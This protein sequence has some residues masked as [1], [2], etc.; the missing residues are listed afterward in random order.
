VNAFELPPETLAPPTEGVVGVR[1]NEL[2]EVGGEPRLVALAIGRKIP[3]P[4]MDVIKYE[5][6]LII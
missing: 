6:L 1:G 2:A 4:S 5:T 3:A